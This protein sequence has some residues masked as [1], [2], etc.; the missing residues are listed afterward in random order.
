M[1]LY[2]PCFVVFASRYMTCF[3]SVP[4][5]VCEICQNHFICVH[6]LHTGT[7]ISP[8]WIVVQKYGRRY[9]TR[10]RGVWCQ[11]WRIMCYRYLLID[12]MV[13]SIELI[14]Q[15]ARL[16]LCCTVEPRQ[17]EHFSDRRRVADEDDTVLDD[18]HESSSAASQDRG[19]CSLPFF[20]LVTL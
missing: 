10:W 19:K 1:C 7:E 15:A 8:N 3:G 18:A 13:S 6:I 11:T 4:L 17:S 16:V 12:M 2:G 20:V 5:S 9:G 14:Y